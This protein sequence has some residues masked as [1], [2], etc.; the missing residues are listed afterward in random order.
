MIFIKCINNSLAVKV[1]HHKNSEL[2]LLLLICYY[3]FK[4]FTSFFSLLWAG[5][6]K[7]VFRTPQPN[8]GPLIQTLSNPFVATSFSNLI[9]W[10]SEPFVFFLPLIFQFWMRFSVPRSHNTGPLIYTFS[11][12]IIVIILILK[13]TITMR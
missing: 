6:L 4:L 3:E 10:I 1:I 9:H 13:I 12:L 11:G 2:I 5:K 8:T 7:C